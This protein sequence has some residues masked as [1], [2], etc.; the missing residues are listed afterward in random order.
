MTRRNWVLIPAAFSA[1][2][3]IAIVTLSGDTGTPAGLLL[4]PIV[5]IAA[6]VAGLPLVVVFTVAA[7]GGLGASY[8]IDSG[9]DSAIR[10]A[11]E[12]SLIVLTAIASR[13]A[14]SRLESRSTERVILERIRR[15]ASSS[16][17]LDRAYEDVY[18]AL[19]IS[20]PIDRFAIVVE[21]PGSDELE[22]AYASGVSIPMRETGDTAPLVIDE[23]GWSPVGDGRVQLLSG[24][25]IRPE[26]NTSYLGAGLKSGL[27]VQLGSRSNPTG[28]IELRSKRSK[29]FSERDAD[30]LALVA[31]EVSLTIGG[32]RYRSQVIRVGEERVSR[33]R[34]D[35]EKEALEET[36]SRL[37]SMN[38]Q[39]EAQ[40]EII[41]QSRE[42]LLNADEVARQ[43][44]AEELHG[45]VQTKLFMIW[46][47]LSGIRADMD[48]DDFDTDTL[49]TALDGALEQLDRIR[50]DDIRLLSHRLHPSI[51]RVSALAGLRSLQEFYET[52]IPVALNVGVEV[53]VLEPAGASRIPESIRLA[54]HRVADAALANVIKHAEATEA[55]IRWDYSREDQTLSLSVTDDGRGFEPDA[56]APSGLGLLTM[57]DYVDA[58]GGTLSITSFPGEGTGVE[59]VI[60][61]DSAQPESPAEP[62]DGGPIGFVLNMHWAKPSGLPAD[63][64]DNESDVAG[65]DEVDEQDLP[66]AIGQ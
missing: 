21:R 26:S 38:E 12:S 27:R 55:V 7:A 46:H 47:A 44:I 60:P 37:A 16:A 5:A 51:V 14:S 1:A 56:R 66:H 43:A 10:I 15:A 3:A 36:R 42:R 8:W 33:M 49:A 34:V 4:L 48:G 35:A 19:R 64:R 30:L 2:L 58:M 6:A 25:G 52:T 32:A 18:Q 41:R 39:L 20:L 9:S 65:D 31:G 63:D 54:I 29:A 40:N 23:D 57:R 50:E 24:G 45:P 61:F 11:I 59:V 22:F 53:E 62:D 13:Y 17:L 28:Y